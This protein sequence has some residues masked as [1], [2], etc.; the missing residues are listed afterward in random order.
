M[1]LSLFLDPSLAI[2]LIGTTASIGSAIFA[3]VQSKG[4]REASQSAR[5]AMTSVQLT[6]VSERLKSAQEHI[7]DI[8]PQKANV[9][10]F[11][12]SPRIDSIRKEFDNVLSA[13]PSIGP[14]SDSRK[15]LSNAQ[16][17]LNEYEHSLETE[18]E[19]SEW[20]ELQSAVQD[21][22]ST[23]IAEASEQGKK[24]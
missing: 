4:A 15:I 5:A 16:K 21:A 14:G 20:Q 10:G 9:R 3:F 18:P 17:H 13:L 8:T 1:D 12:G 23:L 2:T 11:K 19:T 22:V 24:T 6:A 7:R